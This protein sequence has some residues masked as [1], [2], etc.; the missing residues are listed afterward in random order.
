MTTITTRKLQFNNAE[1]FKESFSEPQPTVAYVFIGNHVAYPN[2]ASPPNLSDT[3][4]DEKLAWDNMYAAKRVTG[5]DVELVIPRVDWTANTKYRQYD[6]TTSI[7]TLLS[8]NTSA[9]LKPMYVITP[10]RRVYKCLANN[11]S[12][13]SKSLSFTSLGL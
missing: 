5:N 4:V 7:P 2:E 13:N 9:N 12:A 8:A 10:E 6:D 1:Q 11:S 3:V